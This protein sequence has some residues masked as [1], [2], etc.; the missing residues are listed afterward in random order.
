MVSL[1]LH[2][3]LLLLYPRWGKAILFRVPELTQKNPEKRIAF[4][5]IE[6]PEYSRIPVPPDHAELLSDKNA[7]AR[8]MMDKKSRATIR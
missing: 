1:L 3:P 8:D 6:T 7:L 2:L 5:I 4:E